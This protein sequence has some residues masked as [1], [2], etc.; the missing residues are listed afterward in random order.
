MR[1]RP[2]TTAQQDSVEALLAAGRVAIVPVDL[3]RASA[4]LQQADDIAADLPN[5]TRPQNQCNLAYDA[6]HDIGEA[7]LAAYGYRTVNGPGQHEVLGRFLRA[8]FDHPPGQRAAQRFEQ[9]RRSR[10]Q[11]R[12]AARPVGSADAQVATQAAAELLAAAQAQG[13]VGS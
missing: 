13:L 11:Q 7:L 5:L 8:V 12:Y 1:P 3:V 6:C 2:L 4:F 10:N 9:L